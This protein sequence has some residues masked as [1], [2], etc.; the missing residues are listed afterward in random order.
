[1]RMTNLL[2]VHALSQA[3]M[4]NAAMPE[5]SEPPSKGIVHKGQPPAK[6]RTGGYGRRY[7]IGAFGGAKEIS[8][9]ASQI[10]RGIIKVS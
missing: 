8:R 5:W 1:M 4:A 6:T 9:R 10:K 7:G 2:L 3:A